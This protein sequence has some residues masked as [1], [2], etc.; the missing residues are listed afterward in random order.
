MNG[1]RI[2]SLF[3]GYG[4]LDRGV[5]AA[6]GGSVA[7]H[8]EIDPFACRVL[9]HHWPLIPNHGD[10]TTVEWSSVEPVD[11]VIGG[12]PCQSV[13]LNGRRK[14]LIAVPDDGLFG[15]LS[16]W[17][18]MVRAIA[19]LRPRAVA[20]ENV[21]GL[22][23][24]P[25]SAVGPG[26][27][28]VGGAFGRVLSDLAGIGFDA[29]WCCVPASHAGAAHRRRRVF[30]LA[31]AADT[32]G[33]ECAR[34]AGLRASEQAEVGRGRPDHGAVAPS[35]GWGRF[36]PAI[37]HW[38]GILGRGAPA[39]LVVGPEGGLV[40]SARFMEWHMGL[41][42]G[43]VTEVPGIPADQQRKLLGNG[44][45]PQQSAWA[46]THLLSVLAAEVAA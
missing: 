19:E 5:V 41:P 15:S 18:G 20:V 28:T 4:G 16:P 13:S 43:W 30:V 9:Q 21:G 1:P 3:S 38:E 40:T 26:S 37:N 36:R 10:V 14:G 31:F 35:E 17:E 8:C 23:S 33:E 29:V 25:V 46:L 7:W 32:G 39:G 2:G 24:A 6:I 42:D 45:V 34:W 44:V 11:V 22:L 12:F 27:D